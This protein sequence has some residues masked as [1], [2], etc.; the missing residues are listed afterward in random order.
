MTSARLRHVTVIFFLFFLQQAIFSF[1]CYTLATFE[2]KLYEIKQASKQTNKIPKQTTKPIQNYERQKGKRQKEE[3]NKNKRWHRSFQIPAR[4][5]EGGREWLIDRC[6]IINRTIMS[7]CKQ[8]CIGRLDITEVV[9][10]QH[11]LLV[12]T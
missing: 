1:L 8:L 4:S 11:G 5:G 12:A 10:L 7:D 3:E 6:N 2:K 9:Y